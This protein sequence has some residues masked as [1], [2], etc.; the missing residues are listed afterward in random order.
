MRDRDNDI[1]RLNKATETAKSSIIEATTK[2][3]NFQA[4]VERFEYKEK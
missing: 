3:T 1:N 2:K 4:K